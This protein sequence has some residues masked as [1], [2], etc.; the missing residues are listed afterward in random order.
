MPNLAGLEPEIRQLSQE[1][2]SRARY[3]PRM[4]RSRYLERLHQKSGRNVIA[5]YSASLARPN[6]Y[7]LE[8]TDED[9]NGFMMAVHGLDRSKGLDL[10]LH[11]PRGSIAST[12]SLVHYLRR[13]FSDDMREIVPQIAISAGTMIACSCRSILLGKQSNIGPIDPHLRGIPAY[14]VLHEFEKACREVR[15]DP[16]RTDM[17][18]AIISQYRPTFL[19]QCENAIAWSNQFVQE[20][21]EQVMF[22]GEPDARAKAEQVVRRLSDF[23]DNKTHERHI[24]SDE[25]K[26]IGLRIEDMESDQELQDL[27]LS[28][29]HCYIHLL[30]STPAVK[31]VENH[32]G[33][34]LVKQAAVESSGR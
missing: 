15:E 5:Y 11:T 1:G 10:I 13:M 21:L 18:H 14:G 26:S 7:G 28:V 19:T 24:H 23:S 25:A 8:I 3:T 33:S 32:I 31:V 34:S 16:S 6:T 4:V 20:Q 17:W 2:E 22:R 9:K 12:Q 27:I 30:A 29:H